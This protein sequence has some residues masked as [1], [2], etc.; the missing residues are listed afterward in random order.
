VASYQ[1]KLDLLVSGTDR[2]KRLEKEINALE[3]KISKINKSTAVDVSKDFLKKTVEGYKEISKET[4][5]AVD[6]TR[7]QIIQQIKLNSAVRLYQRRLKETKEFGV[8]TA[9]DRKSVDDLVKAFNVFKNLGD[10]AGVRE[11]A[12]ELGRI[13]EANRQISRVER[14]RNANKSK[15]QE[16]QKQIS[17]YELQGLNVS[18]ARKKL[19]KFQEVADTN[20]VDAAKTYLESLQ[21]QLNLLKKQ[22]TEL[23]KQ[24]RAVNKQKG[25]ALIGGAFPLLFG[26]GPGAA[27]GGAIGGAVGESLGVGGFAGSLAGTTIGNALDTA[28]QKAAELGNALNSATQNMQGLR[29]AGV[30]VTAEA[31]LQVEAALK[32]G[33]AVSAQRIATQAV[34]Q[35]TG[36][37]DGRLARLAS[38]SLSELQKAWNG[39]LSAVST[40]VGVIAAP[41]VNAL[42]GILR[43]VQGVFVVFNGIVAAAEKLLRLVPGFGFITDSLANQA[44]VT[45]QAYQERQVELTKE[46]QAL[47]KNLSIQTTSLA[48]AKQSIGLSDQQNKLLQYQGKRLELIAENNKKVQEARVRLGAARTPEEQKNQQRIILNLEKT[49]KNELAAL[50]LSI[51]KNLYDT[52]V[53]NNKNISNF[54]KTTLKQIEQLAIN[55]ERKIKDERLK[56]QRAVEDARL[57]GLQASLDL[58]IR[59]TRQT[60][61]RRESATEIQKLYRTIGANFSGDPQASL[62]AELTNAVATYRNAILKS[63]EDRAL[64]EKK[65]ALDLRKATIS[66]ERLKR[67]NAIAIA[68]LNLDNQKKVAAIEEKISDKKRAVALFRLGVVKFEAETQ[69]RSTI[70]NL[71]ADTARRRKAIETQQVGA[72]GQRRNLDDSAD[73]VIAQNIAAVE[74]L[75]RALEES[76]KKFQ[77]IQNKIPKLTAVLSDA[78]GAVQIPDFFGDVAIELQQQE[79]YI[80]GLQR[81]LADQTAITEQEKAAAE[82]R[83]KALS[84]LVSQSAQLDS[85]GE[86]LRQRAAYE[87][88]YQE[89]V[90]NGVNP[91]LAEQLIT[92][93]L[94]GD[95]LVTNID[96]TIQTLEGLEGF[97]EDIKRLIALKGDVEGRVVSLQA[98]QIQQF[99][100]PLEQFIKTSTDQL[101]DLESV[102][103][104]VAQGI[105][106][107]IGNSL[108]NG[109]SSLIEGSATVKEVFADMLKSIGQ[110]LVQEGTKMIATYI[111]I[112]IAKIF[113]GM[114]S[115]FGSQGTQIQNDFGNFFRGATTPTFTPRASGGPVNRNSTY[116]VGENGPELFVPSQA[117]RIESNSDMR[118]MMSRQRSNAPAMNFTF[119]TTNIG[120]QEFVSREQLEAAMAVTRRQA[121]SDG[122]RRGM[123]M[124]LDKMQQ[125]PATRRRVGIS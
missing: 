110:V 46:A 86:S 89:Q 94:I 17:A 92:T 59:L 100:G 5:T 37:F 121:A 82:L 19:A 36:D 14:Q 51:E 6:N 74:T 24:S 7:K 118:S 1:A 101:R 43:V 111:A 104:R 45:S 71:E 95:Q 122:A 47:E 68:R 125:S 22:S 114:G 8:G 81:R 30:E 57:R 69:T 34:A 79:E 15:L 98:S 32:L 50:D 124:T 88:L 21:R 120:G 33:D 112:G 109:I 23:D 102:G 20:K 76:N 48:I 66:I 40:T 67:D 115:T 38:G 42:A 105:G 73:P 10:V 103:V 16:A 83:S 62:E 77:D 78:P 107:A 72:M 28:V 35:Q 13:L 64:S 2:I 96:T 80:A 31:Q 9:E 44:L 90:Q 99:K 49:G 55:A 65:I 97:E 54:N 26:Q 106:N 91:A 113:A 53:A 117:G 25:S 11:V 70:A 119:E 52:R 18:K 108:A 116:M 41:F 93:R 84:G 61:Q 39:I 75:N 63:Q 60:Q 56:A 85:I 123:N 87:K 27:V 29:D 3:Q 58:E 12:T 4:T